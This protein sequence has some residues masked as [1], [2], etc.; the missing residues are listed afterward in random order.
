MLYYVLEYDMTEE[1]PEGSILWETESASI[2][3]A[4]KMVAP[5]PNHEYE[6]VSE[7]DILEDIQKIYDVE[8]SFLN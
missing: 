7:K 6:V 3:E 8:D 5:K 4:M 1:N 2:T